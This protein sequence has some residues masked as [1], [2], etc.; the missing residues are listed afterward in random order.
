MRWGGT[1]NLIYRNG[2]SRKEVCKADLC[3]F[4]KVNLKVRQ[5]VMTLGEWWSVL[6]RCVVDVHDWKVRKGNYSKLTTNSSKR[7]VGGVLQQLRKCRS[8]KFG[9]GPWHKLEFSLDG[10]HWIKQEH[11]PTSQAV[12]PGKHKNVWLPSCVTF[13]ISRHISRWS[14]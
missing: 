2:Q 1:S 3:R 12:K 4:L 8:N 5:Y 13:A 14:F 9:C 10:C 7:V 11:E 6:G